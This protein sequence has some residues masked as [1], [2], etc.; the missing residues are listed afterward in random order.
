VLEEMAQPEQTQQ[1]QM[2]VTPCFLPSL[3]TVVAAVL[4]YLEEHQITA[5]RVVALRKGHQE[6]VPEQQIKDL[7]AVYQ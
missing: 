6:K 2:V 3:L 5:V 1:V 4:A 7:M